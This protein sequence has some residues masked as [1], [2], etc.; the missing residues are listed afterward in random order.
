[1][2][3]RLQPGYRIAL[4]VVAIGAG[5]PLV[6]LVITIAGFALMDDGPLNLGWIETFVALAALSGLLCVGGLN[7]LRARPARRV[8][9]PPTP[10]LPP[11]IG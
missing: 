1:M 9:A 4:G 7:L 2:L 10:Y 3:E 11:P 8:D 6:L 5:V